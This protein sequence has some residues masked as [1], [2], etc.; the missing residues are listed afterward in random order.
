MLTL[1]D[2]LVFISRKSKKNIE[3]GLNQIYL[4]HH[5]LDIVFESFI[6]ENVT[7]YQIKICMNTKETPFKFTINFV[8]EKDQISFMKRIIKITGFTR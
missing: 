3:L 6:Y 8:N 1:V 2:N 4:I 7:Y 5:I